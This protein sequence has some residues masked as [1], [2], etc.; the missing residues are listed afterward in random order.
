MTVY[1]ICS[2]LL[3]VGADSG[4]IHTPASISIS[5]IMIKCVCEF[6]PFRLMCMHGICVVVR[7][8]AVTNNKPPAECGQLQR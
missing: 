3:F 5:T 4:C 2:L 1:S 7:H 8:S 6:I